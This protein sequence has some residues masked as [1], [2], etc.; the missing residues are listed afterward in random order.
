MIKIKE[1]ERSILKMGKCTLNGMRHQSGSW[2][3]W[4][5]WKSA[6]RKAMASCIHLANQF[7]AES[8]RIKNNHESYQQTKDHL[9]RTDQMPKKRRQ[10][11]WHKSKE[12]QQ[13]GEKKRPNLGESLQDY[14]PFD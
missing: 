2:R 13:V 10:A 12:V 8:M 5:K 9:Q 7:E 1:L 11:Q 6:Q 4:K 14:G 3:R